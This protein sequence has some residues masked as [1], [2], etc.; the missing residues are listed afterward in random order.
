MVASCVA[1]DS[2]VRSPGLHH[3]RRRCT[4]CQWWWLSNFNVAAVSWRHWELMPYWVCC[5]NLPKVIAWNWRCRTNVPVV[6]VHVRR[7]Y[8]SVFLSLC[9]CVGLR[10]LYQECLQIDTEL[11]LITATWPKPRHPS[12]VVSRAADRWTLAMG[13]TQGDLCN[14]CIFDLDM[15][16]PCQVKMDP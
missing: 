6:C 7:L 8:V 11:S 1:G 9:V 12:T 14:F 2:E 13:M 10:W 16:C 3:G 15:A 4:G 5:K